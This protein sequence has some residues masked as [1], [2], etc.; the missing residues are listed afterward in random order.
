[1]TL[2]LQ[3]FLLYFALAISLFNWSLTLA[4]KYALIFPILKNDT[5]KR[6]RIPPK[7]NR[8]RKKEKKSPFNNLFQLWTHLSISLHKKHLRRS[9]Y[10]QCHF[11]TFYSLFYSSIETA[12]QW[13]LCC[14]VHW[15]F[16]LIGGFHIDDYSFFPE[17]LL[18]TKLLLSAGFLFIQL[19]I[20]LSLCWF[21]FL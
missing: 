3:L 8:K 20:P 18:V 17:I 12:R 6:F 19:A 5:P 14:Q 13:L 15:I 11:L 10:N 7:P 4:Y 21:I 2:L 16:H 1:M 9:F